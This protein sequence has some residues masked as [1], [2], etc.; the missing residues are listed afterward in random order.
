MASAI[1]NFGTETLAHT[2][3]VINGWDAFV[4]FTPTKQ[5]GVV[6]LCSCDSRDVD[7][8]SLGFVL[9]HLARTENL[10]AKTESRIHTTAGLC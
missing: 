4:G 7:M 10:T 2:G 5:I 6:L 9:L 1:T 8:S 3:F